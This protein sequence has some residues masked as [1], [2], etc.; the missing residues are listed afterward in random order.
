MVETVL[1]LKPRPLAE[2]RTAERFGSQEPGCDGQVSMVRLFN[3]AHRVE[4]AFHGNWYSAVNSLEVQVQER[5]I[6][7]GMSF[8]ELDPRFLGSVHRS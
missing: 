3:V 8:A 6:R 1:G 7:G 5:I 4:I 2:N